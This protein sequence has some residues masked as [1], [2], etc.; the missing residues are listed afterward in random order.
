[1]YLKCGCSGIFMIVFTS[2]YRFLAG[3]ASFLGWGRWLAWVA[4]Y[5]T[6]WQLFWHPSC[7]VDTISQ[8]IFAEIVCYSSQFCDLL[9]FAEIDSTQKVPYIEPMTASVVFLCTLFPECVIVFNVD[10]DLLP[11]PSAKSILHRCHRVWDAVEHHFCVGTAVHS[12]CLP[13]LG[14]SKLVIGYLESSYLL[15]WFSVQATKLLQQWG[16]I[17]RPLWKAQGSL[18]QTW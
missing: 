10:N 14:V 5:W 13:L 7:H 3:G 11:S 18:T 1:M 8:P 4:A 9:Q 17:P 15:Q 2:V 6:G 16:I 12:C